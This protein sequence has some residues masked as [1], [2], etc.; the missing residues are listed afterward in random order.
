MK[1]L[2]SLLLSMVAGAILLFATGG[3]A[4]AAS[5]TEAGETLGLGLGAPLP[6]GFYFMDTASYIHRS[7]Q[8]D[9]DALVNIPVVAVSTPWTAFGGRIEAYAAFPEDVLS[10][11]G[12]SSSGAYN[13]ALL[14]GEA[15]DLGHG[16]NFSNFVGGYAPMN[17]GGLAS[18]NWA[19]NERA[20]M[21]Y[22]IDGWDLTS[23]MIYGV[24]GKDVKTGEQDMPDYL[25][26][27]L[28]AVTTIGKWS[29]GPVAYGS[30]DL[31]GTSAG[32]ARQT[33]FAMGTLVGYNLGPAKFEFFMTHD[34]YQSGYTGQDTRAFIRCTVPLNFGNE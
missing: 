10:V 26:Y 25:N 34:V 22:F 9:I 7:G 23:H 28:T 27:D 30:A 33:Q 19:F 16:L 17:S 6:V 13:P 31:S 24:V 4:M 15:W 8:P 12:K 20:A 1:K 18:N 3:A 29:M 14:M 2:S 11:A 21:T 32:T 5:M